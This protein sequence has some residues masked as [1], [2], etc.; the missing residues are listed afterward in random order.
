MLKTLTLNM[1]HTQPSPRKKNQ[2]KANTEAAKGKD[3]FEGYCRGR[4]NIF[5]QPIQKSRYVLNIAC[6]TIAGATA[7]RA[8]LAVKPIMK[9]KLTT[10]SM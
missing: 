2:H 9:E 7:N 10:I 6:V 5:K 1:T 3:Q 8:T 4:L